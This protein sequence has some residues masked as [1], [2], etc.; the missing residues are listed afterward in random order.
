MENKEKILFIINPKSGTTDKRSIPDMIAKY[1]S[2]QYNVRIEFTNH[3]DHATELAAMA[4]KENYHRV[5]AVGGD[6]TMNEVAK[7][8]VNTP[9]IFGIIPC[10]SGNGLARH[11]NIPCFAMSIITDLGVPGKIVKI[12]LEEVLKVAA[13]SEKKMAVIF[14]KLMEQ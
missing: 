13:H 8:L 1:L 3:K 12:T 5:V 2:D 7:S 10:G 9:V 14:K 6:G 11:M 4:V